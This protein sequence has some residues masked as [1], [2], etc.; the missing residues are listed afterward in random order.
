[1]RPH[2]AMRS[3]MHRS[4]TWLPTAIHPA[5]RCTSSTAAVPAVVAH[6][7]TGLQ[8]RSAAPWL[9]AEQRHMAMR[10]GQ[11]ARCAPQESR[12]VRQG[13]CKRAVGGAAAAAAATACSV[14]LCQAGV[15]HVRWSQRTVA[16]H[17]MHHLRQERRWRGEAR[18]LEGDITGDG[19]RDA[20][21][22]VA[23]SNRTDEALSFIMRLFLSLFY[24]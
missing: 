20:S 15:S 23:T 3:N 7:I 9:T 16:A 18:L 17:A 10:Q 24:N 2:N 6:R 4:C 8:Q 14:A 12:Q 11:P 1:M 5:G 13:A 21:R 22:C 19:D